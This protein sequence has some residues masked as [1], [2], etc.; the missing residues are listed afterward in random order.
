MSKYR[1]A[2]QI[3]ICA[4]MR[5]EASYLAEWIDFHRQ[6]GVSLFRIY[7]NGSRD[8]TIAVLRQHAIEPISWPDHPAS[9]GPQQGAAYHDAV[10]HLKGQVDWVAFIDVDEFLFGRRGFTLAE[11][12]SNFAAAS[13]IAVP[14][15]IFGSNGHLT[16]S[17]ENVVDRFTRCAPLD[18]DENSWYKTIARPEHVAGFDSVHSVHLSYGRYVLPDGTDLIRQ[19]G[20]CKTDRRVDGSITLNHYM[21]RSLAEFRQKQRK[22]HDRN[23][24]CRVS[25]EYF[26]NR[27]VYANTCYNCDAIAARGYARRKA[28][29]SQT[30]SRIG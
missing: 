16:R 26:T 23:E 10:Q 1:M 11:C 7:D 18:H 9:F 4:I 14:Q 8:N 6:Q 24:A 28:W 22:W 17:S 12:L 3:G 21:L 20:D 29:R 27:E 2:P 19:F 13:A 25:D 30:M 15:R 5:D